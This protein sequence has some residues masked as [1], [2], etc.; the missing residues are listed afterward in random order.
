MKYMDKETKEE[1]GKIAREFENLARITQGG[2][3]ELKEEITVLDTKVSELDMKVSKLD[4]KVSEL[5]MKVSKLDTKVSELDM[6]VSRI[7]MRTENQADSLYEDMH[8]LKGRVIA[9]EEKV[10][11]VPPKSKFATA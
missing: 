3:L 11:I 10:G 5:D 7:D 4:T 8:G 9:V 1:F 2:F 6:K